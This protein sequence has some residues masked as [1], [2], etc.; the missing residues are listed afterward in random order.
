MTQKLIIMQGA[1]GSGKSTIAKDIATKIGAIV[2]STDDLFLDDVGFYKYDPALVHINHRRN[3]MLA[4]ELLERGESVIIDNTNIRAYECKP[5]VQAA[6]RREIPV[7]FV[8][9]T[10]NYQSIHGVPQEKI[11]KMRKDMEELTVEKVIASIEPK[12]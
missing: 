7:E 1:A 11:D 2:L 5:Y 10:G 12:R 3:Q 9:A 8:R 4:V 6:V